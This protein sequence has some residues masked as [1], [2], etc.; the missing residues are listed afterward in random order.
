MY[1]VP[2][3]AVDEVDSAILLSVMYTEH[4]VQFWSSL[5]PRLSL[6]TLLET[7]KLVA[8]LDASNKHREDFL[9]TEKDGKESKYGH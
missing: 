8:S 2:S 4:T 3:V 5:V 1:L 7:Q 9:D 6:L